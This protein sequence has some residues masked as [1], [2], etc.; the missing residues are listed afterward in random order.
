MKE[1]TKEEIGRRLKQFREERGYTQTDIA[2]FLDSKK[3]TVASW[4]QGKSVPDIRTAYRLLAYYHLTLDALFRQEE[5][6]VGSL[7]PFHETTTAPGIS[8]SGACEVLGIMSKSGTTQKQEH[9][10][11]LSNG[12]IPQEGGGF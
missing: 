10:K 1:I 8:R 6:E 7:K 2:I 4:E 11:I 3:T 12:I 5:E 9:E